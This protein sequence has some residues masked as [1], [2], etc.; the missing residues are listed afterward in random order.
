MSVLIPIQISDPEIGLPPRR[1]V[2]PEHDQRPAAADALRVAPDLEPD[3]WRVP[4][5][6]QYFLGSRIAWTLD[7]GVVGSF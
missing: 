7:D 3:G 6:P 1:H 2:A 5:I 4:S